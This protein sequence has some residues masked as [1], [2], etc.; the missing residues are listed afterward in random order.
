MWET[1]GLAWQGGWAWGM[2]CVGVALWV[3]EFR[4]MANAMSGNPLL[5]DLLLGDSILFDPLLFDLDTQ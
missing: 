4:R 1:R 2:A 5:L 3:W